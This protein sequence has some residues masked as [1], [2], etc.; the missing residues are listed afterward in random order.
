MLTDIFSN[1]FNDVFEYYLKKDSYIENENEKNETNQPMIQTKQLTLDLS[2]LNNT[3]AINFPHSLDQPQTNTEVSSTQESKVHKYKLKKD[4]DHVKKNK[5]KR[6]PQFSLLAPERKQTLLSLLEKSYQTQMER[7]IFC[8]YP[9][10]IQTFSKKYDMKRHVLSIHLKQQN[11][12]C[13]FPDC[14]KKYSEL[15]RLKRHQT[16][17]D[18][19]N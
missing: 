17:N 14:G 1:D 7:Y 19:F 8:S 10:C 18:H 5:N 15:W 2:I 11:Y 9:N 13:N 4:K 16:L 3:N 12:K 6:I